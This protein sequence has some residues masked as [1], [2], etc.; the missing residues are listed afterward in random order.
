LIPLPLCC[1]LSSSVV[2]VDVVVVVVFVTSAISFGIHCSTTIS[3]HICHSSG[4]Q[5]IP[6]IRTRRTPIPTAQHIRARHGTGWSLTFEFSGGRWGRW[7]VRCLPSRAVGWRWRCS[8][9]STCCVHHCATIVV[10][11]IGFGRRRRRHRSARGAVVRC[12]CR[13]WSGRRPLTCRRRRRCCCC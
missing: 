10:V 1:A 6:A 2:V 9:R 8:Q 3:L 11:D 4:I 5:P 7:S 12:V 13:G